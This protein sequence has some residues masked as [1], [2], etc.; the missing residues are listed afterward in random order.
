MGFRLPL[1]LLDLDQALVAVARSRPGGVNRTPVAVE[2]RWI[3]PSVAQVRI[4]RD[5]QQLI[6]RLALGV[7]PL[8]Q[9][10]WMPGV[11]GTEWHFR[12]MPALAEED[13]AVQVP[14]IVL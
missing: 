8:P 10:L 12:H 9:I 4:V 7:H 13:I 5:S 3:H 14:V 2:V 6:A 11:H 1:D